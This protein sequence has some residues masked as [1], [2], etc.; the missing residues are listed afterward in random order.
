MDAFEVASAFFHAC[1]SLK[2]WPGCQEF[3]A[4][5]AT[6]SAQC[7]PLDDVETV[8]AYC[9]WMRALGSGPLEGCHYEL[10]SSSWDAARQTALFFATFHGTHRGE[11]GPVAATRKSTASH[12]VYALRM[13]ADDKVE[14]MTKIWNAPWALKELGWM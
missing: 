8:E 14:A 1:E 12:Y 13:S 4:D 3:V 5:G 7:E 10:H 11:G 9:E 2:G 6:F